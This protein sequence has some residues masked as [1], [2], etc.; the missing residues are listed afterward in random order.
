MATLS[1]GEMDEIL[2]PLLNLSEDHQSSS[3]TNGNRLPTLASSEDCSEASSI[4]SSSSSMS[5]CHLVSQIA[6]DMSSKVNNIHS[7][8]ATPVS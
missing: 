1:P 3:L 7:A 2:R 6:I 8:N 5:V 4:T